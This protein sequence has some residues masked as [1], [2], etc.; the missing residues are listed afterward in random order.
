MAS[1]RHVCLVTGASSGIGADLAALAAADDFDL[2]LVARRVGA[3]RAV[4]AEC[5]RHRVKVTII[6]ADLG[7][8]T[9]S[10]VLAAELRARRLD[11]HTLINNAGLGANGTVAALSLE[12]QLHMIQVN[13]TALTELTRRLL[14]PMLERGTGAILNVASTAAFLPGPHM[15]VYYASKAY[16]LS[17]TD[18]LGEELKGTGVQVSAL[19]PGPTATEFAAVAGTSATKAFKQRAMTMSSLEV[20]RA[21]WQGLLSG[22]RVVVPG[23][24][25]KFLVQ[26]LRAAPRAIAARISASLNVSVES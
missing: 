8:P 11:V 16:V 12:S 19:C 7:D 14:P 22:E 3:L 15:A 20:A 9:A 6:P 23:L 10:R 2:V 18:A 17:F 13:V 21:G 25:N 24:R 1:T 5:E 4:A 26:A